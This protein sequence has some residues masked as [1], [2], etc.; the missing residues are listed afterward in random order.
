MALALDGPQLQGQARPQRVSR[1]DHLRAAQPGRLRQ[2]I[3]VQLG[4]QRQ[5]QEQAAAVRLQAARRQRELPHIGHRLERGPGPRGAL[6]VQA[7]RQGG[8]AL[9][10]EHLAHRGR[11]E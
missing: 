6:I 9:G 7:P 8:K 10:L 1:R 2:R 4:Q 5:E 3:Q 11:A